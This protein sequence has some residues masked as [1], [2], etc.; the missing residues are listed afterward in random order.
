[1]RDDD[2]PQLLPVQ[3]A[4]LLRCA[5]RHLGVVV[6]VALRLGDRTV[7]CAALDL[8]YRLA[9][10]S[11]EGRIWL[12]RQMLTAIWGWQDSLSRDEHG[13]V[14]APLPPLP[15]V[16]DPPARAAERLLAGAEGTTG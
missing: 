14:L 12:A 3:E 7:E 4:E 5:R 9:N 11:P 10:A 6:L 16:S 2:K 13:Q 1:M 15:D 8:R